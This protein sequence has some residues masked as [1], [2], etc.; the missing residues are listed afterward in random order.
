MNKKISYLDIF[1]S[2]P[3]I[4][5]LITEDDKKVLKSLQD[6]KVNKFLESDNVEL[7]FSFKDNPYIEA[8]V[9]KL[10]FFIDQNA[11]YEDRLVKVKSDQID[12]KPEKNFT[13]KKQGKNKV[14]KR[15]SFF[16]I[17]KTFNAGDFE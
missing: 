16:W 13:F 9:Y 17:F 15:P 5:S 12:W 3:Y 14:E 10:L 6:F 4:S 1:L 11:G 2:I 7:E 8:G